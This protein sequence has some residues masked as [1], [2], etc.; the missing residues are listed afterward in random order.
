MLSHF[1]V[2][3]IPV[4]IIVSPLRQGMVV[5][6]KHQHNDLVNCTGHCSKEEFLS[7]TLCKLCTNGSFNSFSL[8]CR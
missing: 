7:M 6:S 1:L 5:G 2:K 4:N 3:S 8:R